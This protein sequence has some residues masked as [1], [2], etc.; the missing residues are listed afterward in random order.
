MFLLV[1]QTKV[2]TSCLEMT[3]ENPKQKDSKS[4]HSMQD[5][6]PYRNKETQKHS[7]H[8]ETAFRGSANSTRNGEADAGMKEGEKKRTSKM[9]KSSKMSSCIWEELELQTFST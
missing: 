2:T 8:Q 5:M 3:P 6:L 1:Q 9:R 4:K 7:P